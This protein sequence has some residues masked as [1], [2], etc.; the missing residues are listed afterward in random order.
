MFHEGMKNIHT[1]ESH[2][3]YP[4]QEYICSILVLIESKK[5]IWSRSVV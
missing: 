3:T 5:F 2:E 1:N 4:T